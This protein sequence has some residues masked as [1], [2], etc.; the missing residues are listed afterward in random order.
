MIT[1]SDAPE[2]IARGARAGAAGYI[3]KPFDAR[4]VAAMVRDRLGLPFLGQPL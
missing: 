4:L 3:T 1:A 2:H